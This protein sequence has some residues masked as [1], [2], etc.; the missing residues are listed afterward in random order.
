MLVSYRWLR[1]YVDIDVEPAR[2]AEVL[3]SIGLK[4]ESVTPRRASFQGVVVGRVEQITPHPDADHWLV[5]EVDLG[6]GRG[7]PG[8]SAI[9]S[10][11]VNVVTGATNLKVGDRVPVALPGATLAGRTIS[12]VDFRGVRSQGM[13]CSEAELEV[14]DDESGIM[15]LPPDA[16][17]G[18]EVSSVLWLDDTIIELEVYANRPDLWSMIGVAREVAAWLG[19]PWRR[20]QPAPAVRGAR[21]GKEGEIPV[22]VRVLAP[23]LCPRYLATMATG[24]T[25]GPSPLWLVQRLRAAGMRPI[26]NVVDITNFVMLETGQPL[27]AFDAREIRQGT[28][29]VRRARTGEQFVT[30]D[31]AEHT[32]DENVLVI[33][34]PERAVALAGI[35]GGANSEIRP[36]TRDVLLEAATFHAAT[37]RR[38]A[39]RL[40][41]RTE[42]SARF[43]KGLDPN[44]PSLAAARALELMAKWAGA[45]IVEGWVDHY[46][47]PVEPWK[48]RFRPARVNGLLGS[49]LPA[50]EMQRLLARLEISLEPAEGTGSAAKEFV[51]TVPTFRPDLSR[52]ADLAEEVARFWGYDRLPE[53][54]PPGPV[55]Q[56][57][58][59]PR[60]ELADRV[61]QLLVA[62]GLSEVITY[63]FIS[64]RHWDRLRLGHQHP[65]RASAPIQNPLSEERSVL[66]TS[67]LPGLLE[68]AARNRTRQEPACWIF[69]IGAVF[70]PKSLPLDEP[71]AEPLHLGLLL[72]G[73]ADEAAGALDWTRRMPAADVFDLKGVLESLAERLH[74]QVRMLPSE[75]YPWLHPGRSASI[76]VAP[77]SGEEN[78]NQKATGNG[79]APAEKKIGYLGELH[80]EVIGSYDLPGRPVVAELD[81]EV[82][83]AVARALPRHRALPEFPAVFRDLAL[84]VPQSVPAAEVER[85]IR[86]AAGPYLRELRLFDVYEGK[87]VPAGMRSLAYALEF[88][89]DRGTLREEEVEERMEQVAGALQ[90]LGVSLRGGAGG[91]SAS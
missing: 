79:E 43:E 41:L 68:I 27:H 51:A 57:R 37:V 30:L 2:L 90:L 10:E 55:R 87:Q 60:Q 88:R 45:T 42:A 28:V 21:G 65:W 1:D 14:G 83:L 17:L 59:S 18:E 78:A 29:V 77:F 9:V 50:A 58:Q 38:G 31:G 22:E 8:A 53:T 73:P 63:S 47:H 36:D 32:L 81:L 49:H 20:P 4:V 34:D 35:M 6:R 71:P 85:V 74:F 44:L 7:L 86:N 16:P 56:G 69:E 26:N 62:Q 11:R 64:P 75:E 33:A 3:T 5:V 89:S 72:S 46:P 70:L 84:L 23:E 19:R 39:I 13:L 25:I 76:L 67:L 40:G 48:V 12:A 15:V 82:L 52:E 61:R 80:P 91:G 54:F 66:R 24:V